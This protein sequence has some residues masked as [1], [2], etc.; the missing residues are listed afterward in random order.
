M[1]ILDV[2]GIVGNEPRG[3]IT[4]NF[5]IFYLTSMTNALAILVAAIVMSKN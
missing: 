5:R 3:K 1:S 4:Y 2:N